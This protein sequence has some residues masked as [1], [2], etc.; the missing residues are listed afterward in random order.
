MGEGH[1]EEMGR[2]I[3]SLPRTGGL[4][5]FQ[6]VSRVRSNEENIKKGGVEEYVR[7]EFA[8]LG[9]PPIKCKGSVNELRLRSRI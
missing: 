3:K 7:A 9:N 4:Q 1:S 6:E 5:V 8:Q 2:N